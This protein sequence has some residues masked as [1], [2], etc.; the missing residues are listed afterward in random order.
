MVKELG[1]TVMVVI[2]DI[3]FVSCYADYIIAMKDGKIIAN[4]PSEEVMNSQMLQE[5]FGMEIKVEQ[6]EGNKICLYYT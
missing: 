2:H 4:G 1:K 5:V 6:I 3:N